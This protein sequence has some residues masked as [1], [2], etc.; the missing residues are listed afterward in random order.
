MRLA[1]ARIVVLTAAS[2]AVPNAG[3]APRLSAAQYNRAEDLYRKVMARC[4]VRK[5]GAAKIHQQIEREVAEGWSDRN[6]VADFARRFGGP[7]N[8]EQAPSESGGGKSRGWLIVPTLCAA[9]VAGW[10]IAR[11]GRWGGNSL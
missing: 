5:P 1:G 2:V 3:A 6:I 10:A 8:L 4:C 9:M 7:V 11:R